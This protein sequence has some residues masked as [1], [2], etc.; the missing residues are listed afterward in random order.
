MAT[1]TTTLSKK[2][3]VLRRDQAVE[4]MI[5]FGYI[6]SHYKIEGGANVCIVLDK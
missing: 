4:M 3:S 2:Y 1:G 6:L 5:S